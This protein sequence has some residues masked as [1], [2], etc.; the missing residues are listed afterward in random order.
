[1]R[2][3]GIKKFSGSKLFSVCRKA[4]AVVCLTAPQILFSSPTCF[5]LT[6][7]SS[8][9][10][11]K[12]FPVFIIPL[13][14]RLTT[15]MNNHHHRILEY[16]KSYE[17]NRCKENRKKKEGNKRA[18]SFIGVRFECSV[19]LYPGRYT[20]LFYS[21]FL[22]LHLIPSFLVCHHRYLYMASL[23]FLFFFLFFLFFSFGSGVNV[24]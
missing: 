17:S 21:P 6:L 3:D 23:F 11:V 10:P 22:P 4:F 9:F 20:V 1:M 24:G 16:D 12:R 14:L 13:S 5:S 8:S 15:C 2:N 19:S 18:L 7:I